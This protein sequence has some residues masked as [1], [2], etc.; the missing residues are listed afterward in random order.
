MKKESIQKRNRKTQGTSSSAKARRKQRE[1]MEREEA[2]EREQ[3][4][5][6]NT[7]RPVQVVN[8]PI[9]PVEPH[10]LGGHPSLNVSSPVDTPT[11]SPSSSPPSMVD[12]YA[13]PNG[14]P[15]NMT[16][17]MMFDMHGMH[18]NGLGPHG[19]TGLV[20][21]A[22]IQGTVSR[23]ITIAGMLEDNSAK[24][25]MAGFGSHGMGSP[26]HAMAGGPCN[27]T[28]HPWADHQTT[29]GFTDRDHHRERVIFQQANKFQQVR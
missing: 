26:P 15:H 1:L 17:H 13:T 6:N 14:I 24:L 3:K 27:P 20:Q 12:P 18:G 7:S 8:L 21:A 11:S 5:K 4:L 25:A 22:H 29:M 19:T 28:P 9:N 2:F 10:A 23:D 16:D